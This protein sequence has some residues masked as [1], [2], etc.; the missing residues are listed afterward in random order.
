MR[1]RHV[2]SL[3]GF[4][5]LLLPLSLKA[6]QEKKYYVEV[7]FKGIQTLR[8]LEAQGFDIGGIDR[9]KQTVSI[10][11]REGQMP[12]THSMKVV[13]RRE[14]DRLDA[15]YK[16]PA[17]IEKFMADTAANY[18]ELAN[19]E[20]FG[21]ST[22]GRPLY[23][24]HLTSTIAPPPAGGKQAIF[25]DS[26]HHAREVMTAEV[27]VD[28]IDY[29]T[30]NYAT[31]AK[32]QKWMNSYDIWVIPMLNPDGNNK[33]W[34]SDNMWRKNTNGAN[35]T[36]I[37]RNYPFGWNSCGGS[38]SS[39]FA[40]DYHGTSAGSEV[41]TKAIMNL[42][43]RIHPKIALSYH[44]YSELV[45]YPYGCS[46][47]HIK[48]SDA[49]IYEGAGKELASKLPRENGSG[50]YDVGTPYEL[51]YDVDGGSEDWL[52]DSLKTMAFVIEMNST[53]A[54]FQPSFAKFRDKTVKAQRA[55]WQY[56]LDRMEGP[57]VTGN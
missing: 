49:A 12:K 43:T 50:T 11:V 15:G 28:I 5:L 29:L 23:V 17:D 24:M 39:P 57:G 32:V 21:K 31:D 26:M 38:S 16:K 36:D 10:V 19:V 30:K 20:V 46:G 51:L 13:S 9:A 52:Y 8:D 53:S 33:V 55:G 22:E 47:E 34:T 2:V 1:Q 42:A 4:C 40:Q 14:V 3:I 25:F 41:E 7:P 54:G 6:A 48:G 35:G 37:N 18:P 27:G 56:L 44:S 45:I